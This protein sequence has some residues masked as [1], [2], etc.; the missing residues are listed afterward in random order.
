MFVEVSLVFI[1]TNKLNTEQAL[2][3]IKR[4]QK[5]QHIDNAQQ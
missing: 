1:M 4:L 3:Q 5:A 2:I